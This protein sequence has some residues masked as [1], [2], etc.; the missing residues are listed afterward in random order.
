MSC[1]CLPPGMFS[2]FKITRSIFK[3]RQNL[4]KIISV[5]FRNVYP[6]KN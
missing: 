4:N 5:Y 1:E 2:I 3:M 6:D